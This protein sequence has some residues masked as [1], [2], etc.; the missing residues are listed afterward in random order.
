MSVAQQ[1]P[2]SRRSWFDGTINIPT[3]LSVIGGA[4]GATVFCIGLYNNVSQRVLL[5]EEHD[6]QQEVHFQAVERDQAALR[7]DVKE[8]LKGISSDV[9]DTNQKLDQLLYN[10]AGVRPDTRG[11][12]R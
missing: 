11:W 3:V 9:K 7:S 4:I 5:L 6:R 1:P 8:Q 12:T 10:R 2:D